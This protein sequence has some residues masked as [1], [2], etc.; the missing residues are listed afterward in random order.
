MKKKEMSMIL[1]WCVDCGSVLIGIRDPGRGTVWACPTCQREVKE[2][3]DTADQTAVEAVAAWELM[4]E[5]QW[6][7]AAREFRHAA[8]SND[9]LSFLWAAILC[10]Y[11]IVHVK[12]GYGDWVATCGKMTIPQ[13]KIADCDEWKA[14]E[15]GMK[16]QPAE[17]AEWFTKERMKLDRMLTAVRRHEKDGPFDIFLCFAMREKTF[18]F[19]SLLYA[20]MMADD[21]EARVFYA[22][23]TLAGIGGEAFE[24]LICHGL[25][26]AKRFCVILGPGEKPVTPWMENEINRY[27]TMHPDETPW[28]IRL[29]GTCM[30]NVPSLLQ[31]VE[32]EVI[33]SSESVSDAREAARRILLGLPSGET[34]DQLEPEPISEKP[35]IPEPIFRTGEL[36]RMP[37]ELGR[38]FM[39]GIFTQKLQ[40]P[41]FR[42]WYEQNDGMWNGRHL[43][44]FASYAGKP[45]RKHRG[46]YVL[47]GF[48]T[49]I[50]YQGMKLE[51]EDARYHGDVIK[52]QENERD[53]EWITCNDARQARVILRT[54]YVL[55]RLPACEWHG[56]S[57]ESKTSALPENADMPA[58]IE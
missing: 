47:V 27:R 46:D 50:L 13:E 53:V 22:P 28:V 24:G 14:L 48:V 18:R 35:V 31:T 30:E 8:R 21:A 10:R 26:T 38:F 20:Q 6:D 36:S 43:T 23:K 9:A 40:F 1:Q 3:V 2:V 33:G 32:H 29:P 45:D 56:C 49:G 11:G 15:A 39:A 52:V 19:T 5:S 41:Q 17:T 55:D 4:K 12:D 51:S 54:R 44:R 16:E 25:R 57:A 42:K 7:E 34:A 37:S 58:S